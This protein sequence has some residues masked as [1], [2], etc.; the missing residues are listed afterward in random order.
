MSRRLTGWT[1]FDHPRDRVEPFVARKWFA[2]N[3]L[4]VLT[5]ELLTGDSLED[6]RARLPRGLACFPRA[7]GDDPVIV[8]CWM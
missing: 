1:V 3:G 4:V 5:N 2:E 6:L 7:D 8:E